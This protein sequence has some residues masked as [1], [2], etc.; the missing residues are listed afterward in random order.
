MD[1]QKNQPVRNTI[2]DPKL[3]AQIAQVQKINSE[4]DVPIPQP[5]AP[6][7]QP[8]QSNYSAEPKK[9]MTDADAQ[10]LLATFNTQNKVNAKP[11]HKLPMGMIFT[12][13]TLIV[14]AIMASALMGY[15]KSKGST[16]QS[17]T[18]TSGQNGSPT[19]ST[20]NQINN[21]VQSC[22]NPTVAISEC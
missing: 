3:A 14:L 19:N 12:I 1:N 2:V 8:T 9:E 11:E 22:S 10:A 21:D 18:S 6:T 5:P 16:G 13:L 17:D 7:M 20:S 15:L 4:H